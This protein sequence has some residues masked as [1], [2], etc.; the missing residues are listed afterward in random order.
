MKQRA[1]DNCAEAGVTATLVPAVETGVNEHEVGEIV[2]FGISH[3]AVNSVFFQPV[4]H[5]GRHTVFDPLDRLTSIDVVKSIA[6]Q[7]PAWFEVSDFVPVPCCFPTCR[8]MSYALVDGGGVIPFTRLLDVDDYFDYV[9]NRVI[10]DFGVRAALERMFSASAGPGAEQ[11][12]LAVRAAASICPRAR[13]SGTT[14]SSCRPGLP[15]SLHAER[16][17]AHE[18]L[19]LGDRPRRPPHPVLRVQLRRLPRA[20][21]RSDVG[22]GRAAGRSER[23]PAAAV[24]RAHPL[25]LDDGDARTEMARTRP[26]GHR[27]EAR[28]DRGRPRRRQS[29]A[30][31]PPTRVRRLAGCSATAT[32]P[33][34]RS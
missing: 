32:T 6:G 13:A 18:V 30:A 28:R 16:A 29:P 17:P 2:R 26:H 14:R 20:G 19:R 24:A 1:L 11:A 8:T 4:T 34:A 21:S 23:A 15:G 5:S 33:A 31:P 27:P 22:G 7:L 12:L 10:P 25:R 3:P 9:S